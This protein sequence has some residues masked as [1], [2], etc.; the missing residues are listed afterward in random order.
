MPTRSTRWSC[1]P[2]S[3]QSL[4]HLLPWMPWASGYSQDDAVR[5][6]AQSEQDWESRI[7]YQYAVTTDDAVIGS[8]GLMR[9]IGPGGPEIGYWL[10]P[11]YT[12]RGLAATA[13]AALVDQT[14]ALPDIDRLEIVHDQANTAS[15]GI[16]RRLGFS[17][18]QRRTQAQGALAPG[19]VGIEVV[20]RLTDPETASPSNK[21]HL[22]PRPRSRPPPALPSRQSCVDSACRSGCRRPARRGGCAGTHEF[23]DH[24]GRDAGVTAGVLGSNPTTP[25]DPGELASMPFRRGGG[26]CRAEGPL[27]RP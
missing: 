27:G 9:Q 12:G 19:E 4:E 5:F 23:I 8:C 14:F 20:W 15:G 24:P 18:I 16:P 26:R 7:A 25:T 11:A 3:T 22:Q 17:E 21:N 10:H 6:T 13:T 2:W 1:S